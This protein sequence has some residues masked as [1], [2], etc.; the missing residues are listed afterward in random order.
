MG[1]REGL[2]GLRDGGAA[3]EHEDGGAERQVRVVL[4]FGERERRRVEFGIGRECEV[5][6]GFAR[7]REGGEW[8]E[9]EKEKL[10]RIERTVS[11]TLFG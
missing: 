8:R 2:R 9:G 6:E 5:A 1:V 4:E 3:A 11:R 7:A 10:G